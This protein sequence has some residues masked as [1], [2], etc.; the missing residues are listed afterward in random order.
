MRPF[1]FL[2]SL[3][4]IS[5]AQAQT[6]PPTPAQLENQRASARRYQTQLVPLTLELLR[7]SQI[8]YA[9]GAS[10][11]LEVLEAQRALRQIQTEYLQTLVG[12][13]DA[14]TALDAALLGGEQ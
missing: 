7:K 8:G 12:L 14:Q 13:Q 3:A 9:E 5:I 6:P 4:F 2:F 1:F 10:T 11:Y